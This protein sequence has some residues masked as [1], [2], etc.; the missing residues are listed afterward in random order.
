MKKIIR[1]FAL[2]LIGVMFCGSFATIAYAKELELCRL[3]GG[4]GD[5][6]CVACDNGYYICSSCNGDGKNRSDDG[7]IIEGFSPI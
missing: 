7:D 2:A 3:C 1:L 5:Y 6:H 4:K